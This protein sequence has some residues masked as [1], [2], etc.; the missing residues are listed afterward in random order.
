M[1]LPNSN[2]DQFDSLVDYA[3][4]INQLNGGSAEAVF[5]I[6]DGQVVTEYYGGTHSHNQA[7]RQ[8]DEHS[9]FHVASVRKSYLGF[10]VALAVFEGKI[11][12]IDDNVLDYLP[13]YDKNVVINT[14]LR[15]LLTHTHGLSE[16]GSGELIRRFA[17]GTNWAYED[18]NIRM[19]TEIVERVFDKSLASLLQE[20]VFQ[21]LQ[22]TRTG[23]PAVKDEELVSVIGEAG[24]E[25]DPLSDSM[26]DNAKK[27]YVSAKE[28]AYWGYFHLKKG[29]IDGKQ[30]LPKE[31]FKMATGIQ[32]PLMVDR[33]LP[34]NGF[35]WFVKEFD[36]KM[37]EIGK[38]VPLGSFQ[39][40]GVT[41]PMLLVVPEQDLVVVRMFNKRYNYDGKEGYLYYI[42]EFGNKTI[43]CLNTP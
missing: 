21:P 40:L 3:K 27:L 37:N 33:E 15:H 23:W 13:D 25:T 16:N 39:I 29:M 6:H 28:L 1:Q 11:N 10:A 38:D 24:Q 36:A 43:K 30:V 31:V 12:S 22:L 9:R 42:R 19:L 5:V 7:S 26:K 17:P 2:T 4:K 34:Q 41:G 18:S 14:T 8:V 32:S 20:R 35:L